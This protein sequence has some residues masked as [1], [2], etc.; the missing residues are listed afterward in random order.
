MFTENWTEKEIKK[1][2]SICFIYNHVE[3]YNRFE[4]FICTILPSGGWSHVFLFPLWGYL[5]WRHFV[6]VNV[7]EL[8]QD[9]DGAFNCKVV[10]EIHSFWIIRPLMITAFTMNCIWISLKLGGRKEVVITLKFKYSYKATDST[11]ISTL[12]KVHKYIF[13]RYFLS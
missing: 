8:M 11:N 1:K 3:L 4:Y 7:V 6:L 2:H 5:W 13:Q 10:L 12:V 9:T